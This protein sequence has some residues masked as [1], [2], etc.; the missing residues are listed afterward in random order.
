[1]HHTYIGILHYLSSNFIGSTK[2]GDGSIFHG[3]RSVGKHDELVFSGKFNRT[4][5]FLRALSSGGRDSRK[6]KGVKSRRQC[7]I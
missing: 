5:P 2:K 1:M 6:E 4:V 3:Y 7:G